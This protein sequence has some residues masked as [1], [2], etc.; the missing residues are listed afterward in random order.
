MDYQ[1]VGLSLSSTS[2]LWLH[3]RALSPEGALFAV[4]VQGIQLVLV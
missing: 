4:F 2:L 3:W 1:V